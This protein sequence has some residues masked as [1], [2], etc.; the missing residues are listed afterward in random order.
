MMRTDSGACLW[1]KNQQKHKT[2][3]NLALENM[4]IYLEVGRK[5]EIFIRTD[6]SYLKGKFSLREPITD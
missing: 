5:G 1:W 3:V 4:Y 6:Y 2:L